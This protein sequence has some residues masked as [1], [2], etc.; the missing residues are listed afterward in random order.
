MVMPGFTAEMALSAHTRQ[1]HCQS[2]DNTHTFP[3]ETIEPAGPIAYA[4]CV[5]ICCAASFLGFCAP[6][7]VACIPLAGPGP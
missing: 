3:Q 7:F 1:Y 5:A 2:L 6:C 4:A